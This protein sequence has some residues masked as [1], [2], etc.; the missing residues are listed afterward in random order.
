MPRTS[1]TEKM[2]LSVGITIQRH[3]RLKILSER[4]AEAIFN[5]IQANREYLRAWLPWVDFTKTLLD[6]RASTHES[7]NRY[8]RGE[9]L[10]LGI[11]QH[12]DSP[13]ENQ[14]DEYAGSIGLV[15]ISQSHQ[16][17]VIGYWLAAEHQNKGVVTEACRMLIEYAFNE[18]HLNRVEILCASKNYKS[19][20]VPQRLNFQKE[21]VLRD[22]HV[23]HGEFTDM[24]LYS[25]LKKEWEILNP[26]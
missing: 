20:A 17:A 7:I 9:A 14:P 25:L 24:V 2:D 23:L 8:H 16:R 15:D 21:G 11:R 1:I 5:T 10:P 6:T 18:M 26:H 22:Y 19:R 4:D 3:F 13:T 12:V